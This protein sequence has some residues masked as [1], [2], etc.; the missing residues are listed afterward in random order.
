MNSRKM[1]LRVSL[2][3]SLTSVA[4]CA[5]TTPQGRPIEQGQDASV[6]SSYSYEG[7]P[8]TYEAVTGEIKADNPVGS[9]D[10]ATGSPVISQQQAVSV[11][12]SRLRWTPARIVTAFLDWQGATIWEGGPVWVV[13]FQGG[14]TCPPIRGPETNY[15]GAQVCAGT[16]ESAIIDAGSGSWIATFSNGSEAKL[17]S[18]TPEESMN[19]IFQVDE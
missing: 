12:A 2:I 11:A 9:F 16:I 14:D 4:A 13:S 19:R 15:T 7:I 3:G 18:P 1:I 6:G 10:Q 17:G 8:V 5:N